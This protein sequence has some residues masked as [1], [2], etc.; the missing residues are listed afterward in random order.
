MR[1][2]KRSDFY[3][4]NDFK[5][6]VVKHPDRYNNHDDCAL[7]YY[8]GKNHYKGYKIFDYLFLDS[9]SES[10]YELFINN[11]YAT[12]ALEEYLN[13]I[14]SKSDVFVKAYASLFIDPAYMDV[15]FQGDKE[16]VAK[17]LIE[18]GDYDSRTRIIGLLKLCNQSLKRE[19]VDYIKSNIVR[20]MEEEKKHVSEEEKKEIEQSIEEYM[21]YIDSRQKELILSYK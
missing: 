9:I 3:F 4:Q 8:V 12:D 17:S 20:M 7:L 16:K 11:M 10:Y 5:D 18:F 2:L 21:D 19:N 15:I 14:V 6:E 1:V 13:D